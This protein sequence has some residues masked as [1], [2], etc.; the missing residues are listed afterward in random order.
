MERK[1]RQQKQAF[2]DQQKKLSASGKSGGQQRAVD[3]S[4][5]SMFSND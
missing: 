4:N 2:E 1:L 3:E 5:L